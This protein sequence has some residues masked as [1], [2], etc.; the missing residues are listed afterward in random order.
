[1]P[2]GQTA[3]GRS[4]EET[5]KGR[6]RY[7]CCCRCDGSESSVRRPCGFNCRHRQMMV[8]ASIHVD[9]CNVSIHGWA[10][11]EYKTSNCLPS[12]FPHAVPAPIPAPSR[13]PERP[14][15]PE[16]NVS[17]L[18]PWESMAVAAL[19]EKNSYHPQAPAWEEEAERAFLDGRDQHQMK[20]QDLT[21]PNR[22]LH[23]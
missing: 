3:Q 8:C 12:S 2:A 10:N 23:L 18:C 14:H 21:Y 11:N 4:K 16:D 5:T 20:A 1:L 13:L 6:L 9:A 7:L 15:A 22:G 19:R 17:C